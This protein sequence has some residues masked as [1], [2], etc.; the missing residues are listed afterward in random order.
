MHQ[1]LCIICGAVKSP[2]KIIMTKKLTPPLDSIRVVPISKTEWTFEYP[3][4]DARA[5]DMFHEALEDFEAG[6]LRKAESDLRLL[7]E[8]FPEFI[9]AYHHLAVILVETRRHREARQDWEAAVEIG[10]SAFPKTFKRGRHKLPWEILDNRPFLRAYHSWGL[11]LLEEEAVAEALAVFNEILSMNPNDNQGIR[12]LAIDCYLRLGQPN[13]VL[14][15]CKRYQNDTMEE[16]L[17]GRPLALF[18]LRQEREARTALIKAIEIL[19]LVAKELMK[20]THRPPKNLNPD[21][22]THGGKDQ[23]YYYWKQN[24][25]HWEKTNGAL[26]FVASV[27]AN[28][29]G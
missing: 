27:L 17:Y 12:A 21:Y 14:A 4:L 20:K 1:T 7:L 25:Q 2:N 18:Q 15:I 22:I 16:V 23:A 11:Q 19:P 13:Q 24:G 3:R 26:Q 9:D 5:F 6:N 8:G 28:R 29:A 10:R